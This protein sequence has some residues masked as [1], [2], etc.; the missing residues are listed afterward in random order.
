MI[1]NLNNYPYTYSAHCSPLNLFIYISYFICL[2][3]FVFTMWLD[4]YNFVFYKICMHCICTCILLTVA[5]WNRADH[6][7]FALRFLSFL[8]L[9]F[10]PRLISATADWMSTILRH[11]MW[12]QCEFRMQVWNVLQ[13]ACWKYRTQKWCKKNRHLS[14]IARICRA[15]SSQLRHVSSIGKK[16]VKQQY[17]LQMSL[18][19]GELL[20]SDGW[21]RLAGLGHPVLFQRYHVLAAL[22]HGSQ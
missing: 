5:L 4:C 16:L 12:P 19:Y 14:T 2:M 10:F 13:A 15:I 20:P 7:I 18:Q 17:L 22:L 9:I 11:M 8:Y 1:Q 6:Y 21:D 3:V